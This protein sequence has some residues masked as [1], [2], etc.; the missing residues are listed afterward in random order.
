[1]VP[2]DERYESLRMYSGFSRQEPLLF[3]QVAPQMYSRGWVDPVPNPL[4]F[5]FFFFFF[6][7]NLVVPGIDPRPPDLYQELWPLDH[8]SGQTIYKVSD[9]F[10]ATIFRTKGCTVTLCTTWYL[11]NRNRTSYFWYFRYLGIPLNSQ[12][13]AT[14]LCLAVRF[15]LFLSK[16]A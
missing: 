7:E 9:K 11:I 4:V 5:Y 15:I 8:R 13:P 14:S 3:Y 1:M 2:R 6:S 12:M 16:N 10:G